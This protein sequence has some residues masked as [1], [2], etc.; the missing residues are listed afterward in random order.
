MSDHFDR[1]RVDPDFVP[2]NVWLGLVEIQRGR[3]DEAIAAHRRAVER[4]HDT[5]FTLAELARAVALAGRHEEARDILARLDRI[6]ERRYVPPYE[7]EGVYLGMGE[8]ETAFV[9]LD[10]AYADRVHSLTF[11][12]VDPRFDS[13]R[14]DQRFV[15]LARRVGLWPA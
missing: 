7:V 13:V 2:G 14:K 5:P 8:V 3:F 15:D 10:R 4:S 12:A 9:L 1:L 11:L 6:G